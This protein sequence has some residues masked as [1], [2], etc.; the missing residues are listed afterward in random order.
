MV[1]SRFAEFLSVFDDRI[2]EARLG[3]LDAEGVLPLDPREMAFTNVFLDDMEDIGLVSDSDTVYFEKKLGRANGKLNGYGYSEDGDQ[4]VLITTIS[5]GEAIEG[6]KNATQSEVLAA[7][8]A[9]LHVYEAAK[10]PFHLEMED[11]TQ[12]RDMIE[13]FHSSQNEVIA[14]RVLVLINGVLGKFSGFEQLEDFPKVT[15]DLWDIER[16]FRAASSGLAYESIAID[17]QEI[18]GEPLPCLPAPVTEEGHSCYFAVIPG[19]ILHQLYHEHGP[20]LLEL[21]VRSFLQARGKVNK[22]IRDTLQNE[23]GYFLAYNNGISATVESLVLVNDGTGRTAIRGVTGLQIVNG[24]QT[25]ASIHRAKERD[26]VDLSRVFVQAKITKIEPKFVDSLVPMISRFSNTQNKVNETDFSANHPFHVKFQQLSEKVWAP[27]EVDR[28]FYER[29]RGQWEVAR[30]REGTTPKKIATF[31]KR[32]PRQ[33]KIDKNILAKVLSAWGEL[34]HIVSLGGQKCFVGFMS[35]LSKLGS[36]WE[37]DEEYYRDS[38]AKI[39]VF[40]RAEKIARQI[41]FSAYQANAVSY[42]VSLLAYRTAGRIN[43]EK[44]WKNQDVS[45]ALEQT[46]RNWMPRV[47]EEIVETAEDRN[48]TEWCKKKECWAMIQ[49]LDLEFPA[50]FEDELAVGQPLPNVGKFS[51]RKGAKPKTLSHEERERQA[52]VMKIGPTEWQE[53]IEWMMTQPEYA[54]F[55]VQ[56]CSTIL[57]YAVIGWQKIP[58]PRQTKNLIEYLDAWNEFRDSQDQS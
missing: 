9:A 32:T 41:K 16:L 20:R 5:G 21:N 4:I 56:I 8:R 14:I 47:H 40:K 42:T 26:K 58:S 54:G 17:L 11:S 50:G 22:G 44:I 7:I 10:A 6:Q 36:N 1:D 49:S 27:G 15:I 43:L 12:E 29:A 48:V 25:M 53:M 19:D 13:R 45:E 35:G 33:Q 24:G 30:I 28:W 37:P 39:M 23:P 3:E 18:L 31:D 55:P 52:K 51:E 2:R 34:P 57:G 46:L 38:V